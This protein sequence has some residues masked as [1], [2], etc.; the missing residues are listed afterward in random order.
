MICSH[1][2]IDLFFSGLLVSSV[3]LRRLFVSCL[4]CGFIIFIIFSA[5]LGLKLSIKRRARSLYDTICNFNE[6][7][8]DGGIGLSH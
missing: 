1:L 6:F 2:I 7:C 4:G 5:S 8:T 3:T